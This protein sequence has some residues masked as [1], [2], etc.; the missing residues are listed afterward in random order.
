MSSNRVVAI[1]V[2]CDVLKRRAAAPVSTSMHSLPLQRT[3]EAL[4]RSVVPAIPAAAHAGDDLR[5]S[6]TLLVVARRV[7]TPLVRVMTHTW[8]W[9]PLPDRPF[10]RRERQP[11]INPISRIPADDSPRAEIHQAG[12][13]QPALFR[14]DVGDVCAPDDVRF[15]NVDSDQ[16][17]SCDRIASSRGNGDAGSQ[18]VRVP[19]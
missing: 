2:L 14:S 10:Q 17:G 8:C 12:Q 13:V 9:L 11:P 19:A 5:L 4:H 3:K 6:E 15:L 18:R 16:S 7:L 1:D